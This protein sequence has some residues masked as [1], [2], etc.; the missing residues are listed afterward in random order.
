MCFTGRTPF[1]FDNA[2]LALGGVSM[3]ISNW[4]LFNI[5]R[6]WAPPD[7]QG[8]DRPPE[9]ALLRSQGMFILEAPLHLFAI[10]SG[11][12]SGLGVVF[13]GW[14]E[15]FWDSFENETA[16]V[17]AKVWGILVTVLLTIAI[18][19]G[20]DSMAT[21]G[22]SVE[23]TIGIHQS[24]MLL[25]TIYEP[26]IAMVSHPFPFDFSLELCSHISALPFVFFPH[27]SFI[28]QW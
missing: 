21:E 1:H 3:E 12:V 23:L 5:I 2:S 13:L 16:L 26:V 9:M 14:D 18:L 17:I 6:S 28:R 15:T 4:V 10:P 27:S 11:I 7:P 8:S 24:L 19:V 25:S 22:Y 20:I